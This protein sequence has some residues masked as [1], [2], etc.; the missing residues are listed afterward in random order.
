MAA[1]RKKNSARFGRASFAERRTFPD[2]VVAEHG[3]DLRLDS[4]HDTRVDPE[5]FD[6]GASIVASALTIFGRR[7]VD[8]RLADTWESVEQS[9]GDFYMGS[10]CSPCQRVLHVVD[11]TDDDDLFWD[12]PEADEGLQIVITFRSDHFVGR[13]DSPGRK[14]VCGIA[15]HALNA[16]CWPALGKCQP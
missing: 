5:H 4:D 11:G 6:G 13:R 1:Y 8:Y 12:G 3:L 15:N 14:R 7:R 10:L 2:D 16:V 9:P